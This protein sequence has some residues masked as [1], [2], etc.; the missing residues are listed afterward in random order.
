MSKYVYS[1]YKEI[2]ISLYSIHQ[3]HEPYTDLRI[4]ATDLLAE[5][6]DLRWTTGQHWPGVGARGE[7]YI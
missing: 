2:L 7:Q 1:I 5:L 4:G 6:C 3:H